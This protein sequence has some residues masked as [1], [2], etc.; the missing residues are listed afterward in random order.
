MELIV[1][2]TASVARILATFFNANNRHFNY[3]SSDK[4]LVIWIDDCMVDLKFLA[5]K[6]KKGYLVDKNTLE[7]KLKLVS[8]AKQKPLSV[9]QNKKVQLIKQLIFRSKSIVIATEPS[10]EGRR[11]FEYFKEFF[12]I[13]QP[14][15]RLWLYSLEKSFLENHLYQD[16]STSCFRTYYNRD[17]IFKIVQNKFSKYYYNQTGIKTKLDLIKTSLLSFLCDKHLKERNSET[18]THYKV[19]VELSCNHK[20]FSCFFEKKYKKKEGAQNLVD[21]FCKESRV[22]VSEKKIKLIKPKQLLLYDFMSL[23]ICANNLYGFSF[24]KTQQVLLNLYRQRFISY[25]FTLNN[26]LPRLYKS[27]IPKI[28]NA[29]RD[30]PVFKQDILNLKLARLY[31]KDV[32]IDKDFKSHGIIPTLKIPTCLNVSE[33]AIYELIVKRTID[34]FTP[35]E[36]IR[37]ASLKLSVGETYFSLPLKVYQGNFLHN[38]KENQVDTLEELNGMKNF[39]VESVSIIT[40]RKK[41]YP[42]FTI[43]SLFGKLKQDFIRHLQEKEISKTYFN[44]FTDLFLNLSLTLEHLVKQEYLC[45]KDKKLVCQDKAIDYYFKT[46]DL[47]VSNISYLF[48][49]EILFFKANQD[50]INREMFYKISCEKLEVLKQSITTLRYL[51]ESLKK[52]CPMCLGSN[53]ELSYHKLV[54]LNKNCNWSISRLVSGVY[55]SRE[56]L[57][58]LLELK[59]VN[60][61]FV[62]KTRKNICFKA[63]LYLDRNGRLLFDSIN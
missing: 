12:S 49:F 30:Y 22:E 6:A 41:Q 48:D 55:L 23:I 50:W 13:T 36:D 9:L 35:K 59:R 17:L 62:F 63:Y 60:K 33:K 46:K 45:I 43:A 34:C 29:L 24:S 11:K 57:E 40:S 3:Y 58:E 32:I 20:L 31:Y 44:S 53:F 1:T 39:K 47:P 19:N 10:Q 21:F 4:H 2:E 15:T 14:C 54:C 25:P 38:N 52:V 7:Y 5:F 18:Q 61:A 42:L 28:L 56:E 27:T 26:Y 51:K 37:K 8:K 16:Y